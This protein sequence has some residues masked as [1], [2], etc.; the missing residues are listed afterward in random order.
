[1]S[2]VS[3]LSIHNTAASL[4]NLQAAAAAGSGPFS[5]SMSASV[6]PSMSPNVS[7]SNQTSSS[8]PSR[9]SINQA[10]GSQLILEHSQTSL[11]LEFSLTRDFYR[12]IFLQKKN[13]FGVLF[14]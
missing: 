4:L 12:L 6:T 8:S 9:S 11:F 2:D 14:G 3:G 7:E 5:G 13:D 1:M 10:R